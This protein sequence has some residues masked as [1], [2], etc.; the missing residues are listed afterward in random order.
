MGKS[1][2][3][4]FLANLSQRLIGMLIGYAWSGVRRR[5][6]R[7]RSSSSVH[8][9]KSSETAWP[10]SQISGRASLGRGNESM[11][12]YKWSRSHDQDGRHASSPP[13]LADRFPGNYVSLRTPAH[14]C[15]YK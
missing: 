11:Y 3:S 13:E 8:N 5:P 9:S 14:Y 7:R 4:R 6:C 1:G 15:L 10:I 2:N 12:M